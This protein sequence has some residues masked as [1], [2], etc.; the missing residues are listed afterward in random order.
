MTWAEVCA[1]PELR[2]L[3]FKVETNRLGQIVMSPAKNRHAFIQGKVAGLL[4]RLLPE[5]K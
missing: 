5:G 3:P 1:I 4:A 2:D